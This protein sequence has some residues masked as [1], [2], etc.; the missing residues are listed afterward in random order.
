MFEPLDMHSFL[1]SQRRIEVT[2]QDI[3]PTPAAGLQQ[4]NPSLILFL[5]FEGSLFQYISHSFSFKK[6]LGGI[7]TTCNFSREVGREDKTR[8]DSKARKVFTQPLEEH[9]RLL[10]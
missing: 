7:D 2:D 9:E 6:R 8:K 1:S 3:C 4:H 5:V 10:T